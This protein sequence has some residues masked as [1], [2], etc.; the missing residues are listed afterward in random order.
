MI[1][2]PTIIIVPCQYFT[3][4][5]S[6]LSKQQP[7][8]KSNLIVHDPI[9][10]VSDNQFALLGF[11]GSGT[12][13]DPYRIEG[14]NITS[15]Q[16]YLISISRTTVYFILIN[17]FLNGMFESMNSII[18]NNVIHGTIENN[19][20]S[21]SEHGFYSINSDF[22]IVSN[23][24]IHDNK[25][26]I[27][28]VSGSNNNTI[29]NNNLENNI[30]FDTNPPGGTGITIDSSNFNN[31][32]N[33]DVYYQTISQNPSVWGVI[34]SNTHNN[35]IASN[36]IFNTEFAI[37]DFNSYNNFY[38]KNE[39]FDNINGFWIEG[40]NNNILSHNRAF[41][42][43]MAGIFLNNVPR[44]VISDNIIFNNDQQGIFIYYDSD[45]SLIRNNTIYDNSGP[46][47]NSVSTSFITIA[48]N[49]LYQNNNG[50]L[51]E[52]ESN[53]FYIANNTLFTNGFT[54][55]LQII[56]NS[57][58]NIIE[59]N[60]MGEGKAVDQGINNTFIDNQWGGLI[61]TDPIPNQIIILFLLIFIVLSLGFFLY[62]SKRK[63]I[64]NF[65]EFIQTS[66][67]DFLK[68]LYHKVI[69]G[70]EN[71]KTGLISNS[72]EITTQIGIEQPGISSYFPGEFRYELK[73]ELKG[74]SVLVLI[75][76]AYQ[77]P[78]KTNPA[79]LAKMLEVSPPTLTKELKKLLKLKYIQPYISKKVLQDS[80]FRNY[81]IT[82]KGIA[83]LQVLKD[84]L[85]IVIQR[86][87]ESGLYKDKSTF[88]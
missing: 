79:Y 17:N 31:I 73:S 32:T 71:A 58:H 82:P 6:N 34:F 60:N 12:K 57:N 14:L 48:N 69:I 88:S 38:F 43:Q 67:Y 19:T 55:G 4:E 18:F 28:L 75:E 61:T 52:S 15:S 50:V 74:R 51:L 22:N 78:T 81:V 5:A 87:D 65:M 39:I 27:S 11:P 2:F 36:F 85:K 44:T 24:Y 33:N 45:H 30:R 13:V 41:D 70:L 47:I 40:G 59:N 8:F 10:I 80:R 64:P 16:E 83:L 25:I 86:V 53:Y 20:I 62:R 72:S 76:I 9:S 29:L 3:L 35:F 37:Q 68:S 23:N 77:T 63:E 54:N 1:I 49:T 66:Q 21:N 7:R 56:G 46:G 42:N 84:N 26:G